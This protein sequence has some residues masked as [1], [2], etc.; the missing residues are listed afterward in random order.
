MSYNNKCQGWVNPSNLTFRPKISTLSTYQSPSGSNTI[1][2][3]NGSNFYSFSSIR[4]GTF[5]PTIFFI[6]SNLIE[7]Y[8]PNTLN[9]GIFPL[10]VFNGS[11]YSNTVNYNIDNASGYWLLNSNKSITNTNNN[12]IGV[13]YLSRGPPIT[14][15]SAHNP[16]I[17]PNNV[18]WVICDTS[19]GNVNLTIPIGTDFIGREIMIKRLGSGSVIS[20]NS[21]ISSFD[22]SIISEIIMS[23]TNSHN[24]LWVTL[25]CNGSSF[26]TLQAG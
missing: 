1:V 7:F 17:L 25:V 9:A 19:Q 26:L 20:T 5:I 6:N 8:V 21:N 13:S 16:Y 11:M 15:D 18:N 10:Q 22:N 3:I 14:I 24:Y 23:N 12:G 4:F 2:A